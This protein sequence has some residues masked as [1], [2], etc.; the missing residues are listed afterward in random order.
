MRWL[1]NIL[2][3]AARPLVCPTVS[4]SPWPRVLTSPNHADPVEPCSD[5]SVSAGPLETCPNESE[6]RWSH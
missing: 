5:V 2:V 1:Q 4:E 6:S 3:T